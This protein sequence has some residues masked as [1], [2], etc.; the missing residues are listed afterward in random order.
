VLLTHL[1]VGQQ[2]TVLQLP[3]P[4]TAPAEKEVEAPAVLVG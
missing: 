2:A 3:A 4:A 1:R